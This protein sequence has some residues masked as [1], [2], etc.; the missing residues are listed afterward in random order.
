[1]NIAEIARR[2]ATLVGN[3]NRAETIKPRS[4]PAGPDFVCFGL[5]KAGTRWLFDQLNA[6]PD[7]WMPPIKEINF[8]AKDCFKPGNLMVLKNG[9]GTLPLF[10]SRNDEAKRKYFLNHFSAYDPITSDIEWYK[11]LFEFKEDKKSGDISPLYCKLD[12]NEIEFVS[13]NL[14]AAKFIFLIRDPV[15][16][17]WSGLNMK[18]RKNEFSIEQIINWDK[19]EYLIHVDEKLN[20][21]SFTARV[22]ENWSNKISKDRIHYWFFEDIIQSPER[23]INEICGFVGIAGGPGKLPSNFNRKEKNKK[24]EMP[25]KIRD[26]LVKYFSKEYEDCV[27]IFGSHAETWVDRQSALAKAEHSA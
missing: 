10:K 3:A 6:R 21:N 2:L 14:P 12:K 18:V 23:V 7:V 8:F 11:Y 9:G 26:N 13:N 22:W 15:D 1:M 20:I 25:P 5:Q 16:R 4:G 19:L 17:F 27:R 24:I